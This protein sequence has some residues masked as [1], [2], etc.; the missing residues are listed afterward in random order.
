MVPRGIRCVLWV[1]LNCSTELAT[2]CSSSPRRGH[3]ANSHRRV[4]SYGSCRPW[5]Y[6]SACCPRSHRPRSG[7]PTFS[8]SSYT[9]ANVTQNGFDDRHRGQLM[10]CTGPKLCTGSQLAEAANKALG[11]S[12]KFEDISVAEA[13]KVLKAQSDSDPSELQYLLEYY[14][15]VR[16]RPTTSP[17]LPSSTSQAV[18]LRSRRTSSRFMRRALCARVVRIGMR[19]RSGRLERICKLERCENTH[20]HLRCHHA[21]LQLIGFIIG[22]RVVRDLRLDNEVL[23]DITT[24]YD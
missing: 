8:Q 19:A 17:R 2:L 3:L 23:M 11:T 6:L 10:I 9:A 20:G 21:L 24:P 1:Q 7:T 13:K 18:T 15:F 14:W 12:M 16:A 5:R 4:A 22:T